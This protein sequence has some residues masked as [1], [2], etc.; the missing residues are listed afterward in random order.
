[1]TTDTTSDSV[2]VSAAQFYSGPD[3]PAN[4]ELVR[5]YMR[6]A[7]ERGARLL[8]TPEN[9]NRVRDF[10]TREAAYELC[11]D[12]DGE[13]I[14]GIQHTAAELGI[15]VAVGVDLR[16]ETAPDV[17]ITQV[18]VDSTG[19]ILHVHHKTVFWDYEYTLFTPGTKPVE[20]VDTRIGRIGMFLCA[21][22]I[23]PEV[24]RIL[25]LKGAEILT[26]S[27]NSRGPDE[28]RVHEPLRAIE[29]HVW[30]VAANTVSGPEDAYP[31]TGGSQIISPTGEVLANAGEE[32]AGMVVADITPATSFP[33]VLR[34]IGSLNQYRRPDL[35][36]ELLQ[37][38]GSHRVAE[39]YG[40]VP[41]DASERPLDVVTL[42]LSWYHSTAWT[43][44]RAVGQIEYAAGRG[45]QLGVF[46][47][48]F[49]HRRGEIADNPAAA[50][51][52]SEEALALITRAAADNT[53][54]IVAS[55]V[56][57]E[58]DRYFSTAYLIGPDGTVEGKYR[59]A[60]LNENER[61]WATPGDDFVVV[62]TPIGNIGLMIG[63]EV[64][65]P[66][67]ARI[68]SLRGAEVIA[69]PAD[70]DRLEAATMA[71]TERTEE[72]RTHL[73]SS[74]RADNPAGYG[75]QIVV[76]DRFRP[77]QPIALMR[78]PTAVTS[79]TG[80]EENIFYRLDLMDSRSK[81]QGHHL[82]PLATRQPHLYDVFTETPNS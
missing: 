73:V 68:L 21:D 79:R 61:E 20:V 32:K 29:N 7:A 30:H 46:P 52:R 6:Q 50:A 62:E 63:D 75:S 71:A 59:K 25:A 4:L 66:E 16:A 60:H 38:V 69:H 44:K 14:R 8:V 17:Y 54:W 37:D 58:G 56:E 82:D 47:E 15:M 70:W 76:A 31:W 36:G 35:Y 53:I 49:V 45:A 74:A 18:L 64:W 2:R 41:E 13:F 65:L 1:M 27:L 67:V 11:E 81:V 5:G 22:G 19:E 42:Q 55:L 33:K 10:T 57:R 34:G 24:P 12:L 3:V 77:G 43:L 26:N 39:W 9:S 23:V 40:P 28:M 72:N 48:L 78:Y 80:F 51:D